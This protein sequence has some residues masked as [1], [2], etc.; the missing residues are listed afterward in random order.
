MMR[1]P[2]IG[3]AALCA[4]LLLSG[5]NNSPEASQITPAPTSTPST[6][7]VSTASPSD[8]SSWTDDE[9]KAIRESKARYVSARTAVGTALSDPRKASRAPL[10]LAGNGGKWLADAVEE[11][12]FQRDRGWYQSG[13]AK[14]VSTKVESVRLQLEQPEILLANCIDSSTLVM[15]YRST[16]KPVPV[17]PNDGTRHQVRSRMVLGPAASGMKAWFLVDENVTGSC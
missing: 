15:R 5:C 7:S 3:A 17:G 8:S 14:V 9:A 13:S 6:A 10:E 1:R 4:A 12:A 2:L 16:G 11:I